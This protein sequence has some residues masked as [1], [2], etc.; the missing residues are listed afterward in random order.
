[1]PEADST[2]GQDRR[3]LVV[4]VA[5][6]PC[7]A[8]DVAA[9]AAAHADVVWRA[10]A[11][12]VV[13]PELSITGYELDAPD[14]TPDDPRLRPIVEACAST[15]S[16]ALVGAPVAGPDGAPSRHIGILAIDAG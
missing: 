7:H 13:F 6:P 15:G 3:A 5:Q 1:M 12:V 14:V 9:N 16:L 4:A 10:A 8:G 2:Q 11:R